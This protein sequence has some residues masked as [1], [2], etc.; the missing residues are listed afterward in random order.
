M[1]ASLDRQRNRRGMIQALCERC[2]TA[3]T[4]FFGGLL[5]ADTLRMRVRLHRELAL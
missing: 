5:K 4:F 2:G 1:L 3:V